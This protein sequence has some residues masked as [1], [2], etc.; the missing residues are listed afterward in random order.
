MDGSKTHERLQ[1]LIVNRRVIY[2]VM[3]LWRFANYTWLQLVITGC[4]WDY[5]FHDIPYLG[6]I[7]L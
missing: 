6:G 5:T 3:E 2:T 4:K 7:K 1:E